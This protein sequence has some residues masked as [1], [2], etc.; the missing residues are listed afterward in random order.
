MKMIELELEN[1][2]GLRGEHNL[3]L[4]EGLNIIEA[5][6]ATGKT[7]IINGIR[8]LILPSEDIKNQRHF[9]NLMVKDGKVSAKINNEK[10]VREIHEAGGNLFVSGDSLFEA[11]IKADVLAVAQRGNRLLN[12][13]SQGESLKSVLDEFS[14][15]RYYESGAQILKW[16]QNAILTELKNY[17]EEQRKLEEYRN[18]LKELENEKQK[19]EE[20]QNQLERIPEAS[21]SD[22][23]KKQRELRELNEKR[24]TRKIEIQNLKN[25]LDDFKNDIKESRRLEE[26]Y[27]K[28]IEDFSQRHP[29][30]DKEIKEI[31]NDISELMKQKSEVQTEQRMISIMLEESRK[32]LS[33]AHKLGVDECLACGNKS[34]SR[35]DA[36]IRVRD[37]EKKYS[38]LTKIIGQ[39]NIEIEQKRITIDS[40]QEERQKIKTEFYKNLND[41]RQNLKFKENARKKTINEISSNEKMLKELEEE[42]NE[43]EEGFNETILSLMQEHE[44]LRYRMGVNDGEIRR[45]QEAINESADVTGVVQ[46][47]EKKYEFLG[48]TITYMQNKAKSISDELIRYFN[49]KIHEVYQKL[50]FK[51]FEKIY[52]DSNTFEINIIRKTNGNPIRQ[53]I[54]SLSDSER[55][56][57]G[58]I[59]ML[60]GKEQFL[61]NFPLFVLD[62][63]TT[64]YDDTRFNSIISYLVENVTYVLVTKLSPYETTSGLT[65]KHKF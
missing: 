21:A 48:Q 52:I 40:L 53:P 20:E 47:S 2:G 3:T 1:I 22:M 35:A 4:K 32:N 18:Q 55:N 33:E 31:D 43:T 7:S 9:L 44:D 14:D 28:Q 19:L 56:T 11:D 30:I 45:T 54:S 42:I 39:I 64:D 61:P 12:L 29:D 49:T 38:E 58:I 24:T 13:V 17:R 36:E 25:R 5:P 26:Y 10:F 8:S 37:L 6:N 27:E 23:L 57:I 50:D 60:A 62:A 46:K 34:F 41:V 59:S 63:V 15:S 65:I 51:D 16:K